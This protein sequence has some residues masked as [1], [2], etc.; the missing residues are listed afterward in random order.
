MSCCICHKCIAFSHY[1][2]LFYS[3]YVYVDIQ[4]ASL[5]HPLCLPYHLLS[6]HQW[7]RFSL[8]WR[9]QSQTLAW[10]KNTH[11]ERTHRF[12]C[13]VTIVCT[14]VILFG[15]AFLCDIFVGWMYRY[16][17]FYYDYRFDFHN[18][19]S[20]IATVITSIWLRIIVVGKII[21]L[22]AIQ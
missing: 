22:K 7:A 15:F 4:A 17:I 14:I 12:F 9:E 6:L 2:R 19:I 1:Y 21:I 20:F 18:S 13:H 10:T 3:I 11:F 16:L 8:K 5:V